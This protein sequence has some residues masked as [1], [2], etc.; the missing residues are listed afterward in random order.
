LWDEDGASRAVWLLRAGS[1]PGEE[2]P[3][4]RPRGRLSFSWKFFL[5]VLQADCAYSIM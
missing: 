4:R 5:K 1:L 3:I 2:E